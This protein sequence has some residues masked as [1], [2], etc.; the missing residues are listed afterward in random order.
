MTKVKVWVLFWAGYLQ[1]NRKDVPF[2]YKTRAEARRA[3][4][5]QTTVRSAVLVVKGRKS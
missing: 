5:F 2:I 1:L 3:A 4:G